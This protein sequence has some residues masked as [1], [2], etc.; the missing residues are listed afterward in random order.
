MHVGVAAAE[1]NVI[2]DRLFGSGAFDSVVDVMNLGFW[3]SKVD[4]GEG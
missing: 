3:V 1:K 2:E 4:P